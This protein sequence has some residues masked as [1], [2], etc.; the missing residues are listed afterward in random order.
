MLVRVIDLDPSQAVRAGLLWATTTYH[1]RRRQ[2]TLG[3]LTPVEFELGS[4]QPEAQV[5]A[6][7]AIGMARRTPDQLGQLITRRL[8]R[9]DEHIRPGVDARVTAGAGRGIDRG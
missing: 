6:Y 9:P 3:R 2:D 7:F 5:M 8:M 1:R 4:D